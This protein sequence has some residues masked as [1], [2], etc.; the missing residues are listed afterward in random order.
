MLWEQEGKSHDVNKGLRGSKQIEIYVQESVD[1]HSP[2]F[3]HLSISCFFLDYFFLTV[4]SRI[5]GILH[6]GEQKVIIKRPCIF[7]LKY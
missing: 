1:S 2:F 5:V 7:F 6:D 4:H 3:K